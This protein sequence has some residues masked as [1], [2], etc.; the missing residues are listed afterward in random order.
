MEKEKMIE[1]MARDWDYVGHMLRFNDCYMLSLKQWSEPAREMIKL[2]WIKLNKNSVV[3]TREEYEDLQTAKDF[4]YGYNE[5]EKNTEAYYKNLALPQARKETARKILEL[6]YSQ[7]PKTQIVVEIG[8]RYGVEI[9]G[10]N[11]ND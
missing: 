7:M 6:L 4:D 11:E 5:G 8:K 3:L 9:K 2:G 10:G 1:E